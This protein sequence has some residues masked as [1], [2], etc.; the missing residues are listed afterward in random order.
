MIVKRKMHNFVNR[1]P[2]LK[3]QIII[4]IFL[5]TGCAGNLSPV[6]EPTPT[7][8]IPLTPTPTLIPLPTFASNYGL[9]F[10]VSRT[11]YQ[12]AHDGS[13]YQSEH[14][15]VY[16]NGST[17]EEKILF[18]NRAEESLQLIMQTLHVSWDEVIFP[19]MQTKLE[20]FANSQY[21][22]QDWTGFA[23]YGGFLFTYNT[24]DYRVYHEVFPDEFLGNTLFKHEITHD[25]GFLLMG[26]AG[27]ESLMVSTWF[28]EGLAEYVSQDDLYGINSWSQFE[29]LLQKL[30]E[31]PGAGNPTLVNTWKEMPTQYFSEDLMSDFY[32]LSELA[33]RYLVDTYGIETCKGI[34]L[35]V[36]KGMTFE[37]AFEHQY[38]FSL[39]DLQETFFSRMESYL[40]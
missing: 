22:D 39:A 23:Y 33:I 10:W 32:A 9:G 11:P 6:S 18:A 27:Q 12:W 26:Y 17:L 1:L 34:Y 16:A 5:I 14:F 36:R 20:I 15:I 40:P 7:R 13:P 38:G 24:F 30:A 37:Q 35:D 28:D 4:A 29:T 3:I 25:V 19:P 21:F 31:I 2:W 8:P